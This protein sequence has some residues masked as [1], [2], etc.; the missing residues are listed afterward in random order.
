M[1]LGFKM[2]N[3]WYGIYYPCHNV[4]IFSALQLTGRRE[5]TTIISQSPRVIMKLH[6]LAY[7]G[8]L[9]ILYQVTDSYIITRQSTQNF[10]PG[11]LHPYLI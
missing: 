6:R 1:K 4:S 8:K 5:Q 2:S 7:V 9:D 11:I 10:Y 3:T